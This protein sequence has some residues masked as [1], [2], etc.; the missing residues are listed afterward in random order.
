MQAVLVGDLARI[1][2]VCE[3]AAAEKNRPAA[4]AQGGSCLSVVAGIGFEPMTFRL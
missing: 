3:E 1:L 4:E 2:A